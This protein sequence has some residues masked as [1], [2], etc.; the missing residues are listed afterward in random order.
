MKT[1]L[2]QSTEYSGYTIP[3]QSYGYTAMEAVQYHNW[4]HGEKV[5]DCKLHDNMTFKSDSYNYLRPDYVPI[6][7]VD[8]VLAWLEQMGVT[9]VAPL[10]IPRKLWKYCRR[11]VTIDYCT[12]INGH[13]MLKDC[14][15]IKA[16]YNGEAYFNGDG[17]KD[18][19]YF[20]TRWVDNINSEWRVF[21][22][23]QKI[24]S[25]KCYSGDELV[26]PDKLYIE[27]IVQNY[28]KR[29]YTLDVMV[30]NDG[31]TTDI[32][33]LHDFFACGLYGFD[34]YRVLLLMW[35]STIKD[36]LKQKEEKG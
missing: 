2:I 25:I 6:G 11:D 17:G 35:T 23:N 21:V 33:E 9:D 22:F 34:D 12:N 20:L 29:C 31:K 5:Y 15:K 7:S 14:D 18:K 26:I 36:M 10:N 24:Q 30:Y 27:E 28:D 13:W 16:D 4:F 8:Y 3:A 32:V 19:K 1:F